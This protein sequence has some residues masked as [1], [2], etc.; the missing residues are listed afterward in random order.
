MA[1]LLRA[2]RAELRPERG[3]D[4]FLTHEA[5][6]EPAGPDLEASL[7][8]RSRHAWVG[9]FDDVVIGYL[10]GR[11]EELRDG[12]RLGIVEDIFVEAGGPGGGT[13]EGRVGPGPGLVP[14]GR[15]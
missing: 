11:I 8:D 6:A 9:T 1:E 12:R 13:R 7:A 10:I 5:R 4:I 3:G 15:V 14:P 2:A